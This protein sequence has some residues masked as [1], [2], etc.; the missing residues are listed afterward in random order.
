MNLLSA[1]KPKAIMQLGVLC[2]PRSPHAPQSVL[3]QH[4][5]HLEACRNA[6]P[7]PPIPTELNLHF[8]KIP[9]YFLEVVS[10]GSF[11]LTPSTYLLELGCTAQ[12]SHLSLP[13]LLYSCRMLIT[14][15]IPGPLRPLRLL[16]RNSSRPASSLLGGEELACASSGI[17]TYI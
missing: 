9:G 5:H 1:L 17:D 15:R 14:Q 8:N 7:D 11:G 4:E 2:P 13:V 3:Q 16:H 12:N 10:L 6:V